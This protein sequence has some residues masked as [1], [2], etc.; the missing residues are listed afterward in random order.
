VQKLNRISDRFVFGVL[1]ALLIYVL[2]F[3]YLNVNTVKRSY[4]FESYFDNPAL[5]I[6]KEELEDYEV[7][8]SS[9]NII[10]PDDYNSGDVKNIS[11]D[12][13]DT[14]QKSDENW[15][16]NK[17]STGSES[18]VRDFERQLF[19]EMGGNKPRYQPQSSTAASSNKSTSAT[20]SKESVAKGGDKVYSGSV[21]VDWSL[22]NRNP[23]QN[24]NWYV[25]NPGY[26]CGHGSSGKVVVRIYVNQNGDVSNAE[27]SS[28][29]GANACMLEQAVKYAKK[30]RFNYAASAPK[31]QEGTIVYTF[32]SQ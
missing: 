2:V 10:V 21:M 13:N 16:E 5:D 29:S 12:V 6:S 11:R 26:T 20:N 14:R 31:L 23:H 8:V 25:R 4:V 22:S 7:T 1:A 30:S 17:P 19:E 24:N 3:V 15:S 28:S 27:V 18:S 9:E 32:V